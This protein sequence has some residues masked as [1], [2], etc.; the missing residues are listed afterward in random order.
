MIL[1]WLWSAIH[2]GRRLVG[3]LR[4]SGLA[5]W[6]AVVGFIEHDDL[7]LASSISYYGLLS[8]FPFLMLAFAVLGSVTA[9][10]A[11]RAAV[12]QFV[13]QYLPEQSELVTGQ[14]D[15]LRQASLGLGTAGTALLAWPALGLFRSVTSAVNHA[16]RAE[17]PGGYLQHHLM[18]FL[19]LMAAGVLLVVALLLVSAIRV[20]QA[21][22]FA[23]VL[24]QMPGLEILTGLAFRYAATLLPVMVVGWIFYFVPNTDVR[25]RDVWVGALLTGWLWR[26]AF[27][28][29]S[30]YVAGPSWFSIPGSVAAIVVFLFWVQLEASI[31]LYGAEFTAAYARLRRGVAG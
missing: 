15:A 10:E 3:W 24:D 7:T 6:R 1:S 19:M 30:W 20:V 31:L 9:D 8:L 27:D 5:A 21:S 28:G 26:L 14:L 25:L 18:A 23:T 17:Q 29:F 13:L 16:W 2:A 22:W 4:I 12:L 11:D